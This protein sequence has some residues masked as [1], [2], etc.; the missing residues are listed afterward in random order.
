MN[1]FLTLL[2]G[3]LGPLLFAGS[4]PAQDVA[5]FTAKIKPFG[6]SWGRREEGGTSAR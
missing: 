6:L 3:F 4:L 1:R 2:C 5:S